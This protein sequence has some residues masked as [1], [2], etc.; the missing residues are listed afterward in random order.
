MGPIESSL[1]S[2]L[3]Q[4]HKYDASPINGRPVPIE[5]INECN[6]ISEYQFLAIREEMR[7]EEMARRNGEAISEMEA[8][9][10]ELQ[11]RMK[12]GGVPPKYVGCYIDATNVSALND[13]RWLY[14]HGTDQDS[15][16]L[17]ACAAAKGWL[18]ENTYGSAVYERS[19]SLLA[20]IR[21]DE[22]HNMSWFSCVGL[23]IVTNVGSEPPTE[24][25]MSKFAD[26]LD[27]R[28]TQGK[29][30]S[31]GLPTII[32]SSLGPSELAAHFASRGSDQMARSLMNMLKSHAVLV[33]A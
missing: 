28:M 10:I 2:I 29:P 31:Y 23:L 18:R 11:D 32:T 17:R 22:K 19:N 13:G 26:L 16:N 4:M 20:A 9:A 27:R 15:V 8:E 1:P 25:A 14:V 33:S 21:D 3:E 30:P 24:W 7:R 12:R 6:V 5:A